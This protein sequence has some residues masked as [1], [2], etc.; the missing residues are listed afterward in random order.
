MQNVWKYV[1]DLIGKGLE[2]KVIGEIIIYI[3]PTLVP[4]ALPLAILLSSL[5]AFG[6]LSENNELTALKSAG[7]SLF[8]IMKPMFTLVCIF[9]FC[10]FLFSNHII[11]YS[12][13]KFK[14]L[15]YDIMNKKLDLNIREGIFFNDI[16]GFSIK[17]SK[18]DSENNQLK[19]IIIYDHSHNAGN[20]KVILAES[21]SMFTSENGRYLVLE[22][23]NGQ[24]YEEMNP[25]NSKK[26]KNLPF[27]RTKFK[28]EKIKFDLSSFAFERSDEEKY[29]NVAQFMNLK[30]LENNQDSLRSNIEVKLNDFEKKISSSYSFKIE[31]E[32]SEVRPIFSIQDLSNKKKKS[33]YKAASNKVR[34]S[35]SYAYNSI[36]EIKYKKKKLKKSEIEW[37]RKFSL[38]FACLILFLIGAPLG[39]LIRKGGLG[40]PVLLSII[41]FLIYHI[42]SITAEKSALQG[43]FSSG[44][45]MWMSTMVLTPLGIFFCF[46]AANDEKFSIPSGFWIFIKL[47]NKWQKKS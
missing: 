44:F 4:L 10:A 40:L 39:A 21:G 32:I 41:F 14:T 7:I 3:I 26:R 37:H 27:S 16:E 31:K 25:K 28:S 29:S 19:D 23:Y 18:K 5:M 8:K 2:L 36:R 42:I 47:K 9:A 46:N 24:S 45:G 20:T 22:L 15:L 17:V 1:D 30:E 35:K 11:P 6:Q 33:V 38:P 34:S 13:L 12:N 43:V